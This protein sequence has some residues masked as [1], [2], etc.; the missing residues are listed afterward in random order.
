MGKISVGYKRADSHLIQ[1]MLTN[2]LET[3]GYGCFP[4]RYD[5]CKGSVGVKDRGNFLISSI[6][7]KPEKNASCDILYHRIAFY[8]HQQICSTSDEEPTRVT[9]VSGYFKA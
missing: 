6:F 1:V 9:L 5:I 2:E 7:S 3:G 4:F 8:E